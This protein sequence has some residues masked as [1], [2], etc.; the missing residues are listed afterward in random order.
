MFGWKEM[1]RRKRGAK[2]DIKRK[3]EGNGRKEIGGTKSLAFCGK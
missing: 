3:G 1:K 2:L